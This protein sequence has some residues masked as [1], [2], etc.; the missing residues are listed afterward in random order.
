MIH[1]CHADR[2]AIR[3]SGG[4]VVHRGIDGTLWEWTPKGQAVVASGGKDAVKYLKKHGVKGERLYWLSVLVCV[5]NRP[6][7]WSYH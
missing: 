4:R 2:E 7:R 6:T 5:D 3:L 1:R